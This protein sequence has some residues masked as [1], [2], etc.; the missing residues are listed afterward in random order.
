MHFIIIILF[1]VLTTAIAQNKSAVVSRDKATEEINEWGNFYTYYTGETYGTKDLLTGVAVIKPG[2]EIH[3]PHTHAEEEFLMI[4]EGEGK[5]H[6]NGKEFPAKEGDILYAE[7]WDIH[8]ISNT[9]E[10]PLKFVIW[11]WNNK[12]V[13]VP[14][15][16]KPAKPVELRVDN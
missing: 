1:F 16:K 15:E 8:G 11:K 4:I 5:W 13:E 3:P 10:K 9:G 12:G 7:P 6:L 14:A 2:M